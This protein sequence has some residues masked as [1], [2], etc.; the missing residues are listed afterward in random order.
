MR[1]NKAVVYTSSYD[2][3][4]QFLLTIWPEV[5]KEVPEAE[6][7]IYYGWQLF[8]RFYKDNPERMAWMN[9]MNKMMEYDGI[10]H[11]GRVPQKEII[12]EMEKYGIWAYP[13]PFYEISCITA[14]K[15][16][17]CGCVPV[18]TNFAALETTV[19]YGA[20]V[21]GD[22]Y[23]PEVLEKF[24]QELITML[25]DEKKQEEIRKEILPKFKTELN[26]LKKSIKNEEQIKSSTSSK[27]N[28][29][30]N[31]YYTT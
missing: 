9:E 3:G 1:N 5:K 15:S 11:H 10:T 17:I 22:I 25:K 21:D 20:K 31:K 26:N 14:M 12:K 29:R 19:Q 2:R 28:R 27:K 24:K 8:E 30:N 7:H 23:D 18:C 13:T 6:L 4:L 16:Q